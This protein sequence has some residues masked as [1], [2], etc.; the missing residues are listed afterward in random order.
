MSDRL[1]VI[2]SLLRLGFSVIPIKVRDKKPE[3]EWKD[4]QTRR[5]TTEQLHRWFGNGCPCNIGIVT[6]DVSG[7]IVVDC[8]S[9]EA[10]AWAEAN[11]PLTP[12]MTRTAKGQHRF[13]RHPGSQVRNRAGI[14]TGDERIKIDVRGDGG[15]VVAPGS[16]HETGHVYETDGNWPDTLDD[17]PVFDPAWLESGLK[18]PTTRPGA[19]GVQTVA[20]GRRNER[21]ASLAG[22][23]RRPGMSREAI[24]AALLAENRARCQ[25]PLPDSEVEDIAASVARYD[26][27]QDQVT[28]PMTDAGNGEFI[29]AQYAKVLRFD[30]RRGQY[31]KFTDHRWVPDVEAEVRRLAKIAMRVRFQQAAQIE[32]LEEREKAAKW[33]I[34][35]ESRDKVNAALFFAQSE[36][37]ISDRGEAWDTK[38]LLLGV[39]KRRCRAR[40]RDAQTGPTRGPDHHADAC[41]LSP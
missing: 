24:T 10:V 14:E 20:E 21:L 4:Y 19:D 23:M 38:P 3:V 40:Y 18:T 16:V 15:Y 13:Y 35:S 37:Q 28:Y 7:V 36:P 31:L 32:D 6:G 12:M 39:S 26:A 29:A 2:D 33:A 8:D 27:V 34:R 41:R 9:L 1:D 30:H 17:V 5:P 22:S 11:L 25:P